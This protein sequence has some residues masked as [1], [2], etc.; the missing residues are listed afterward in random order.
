MGQGSD[1]VIAVSQIQSL[2]RE[3]LQATGTT[4]KKYA[5]TNPNSIKSEYLVV[6]PRCQ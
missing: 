3:F 1:I 6:R 5:Q 2:A 4:K